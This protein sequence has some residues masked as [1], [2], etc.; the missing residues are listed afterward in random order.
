M[1]GDFRWTYMHMPRNWSGSCI[2]YVK[3][4]FWRHMFFIAHGIVIPWDSCIFMVYLYQQLLTINVNYPNCN[5][6]IFHP[7]I[8]WVNI[9]LFDA[10]MWCCLMPP[11]WNKHI[12]FYG[13]GRIKHWNHDLDMMVDPPTPPNVPHLGRSKE[14]PERFR[15]FMGVSKNRG[16][17]KWMEFQWKTLLKWM[18]WGYHHF[19]KHPYREKQLHW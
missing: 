2:I 4:M 11:I 9:R 18:I 8:L 10:I 17:P 3:H 19:R 5:G 13:A 15:P 16:T 12:R 6:K 1:F 7:W 14:C